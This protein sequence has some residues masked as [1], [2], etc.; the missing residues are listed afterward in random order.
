LLY[1]VAISRKLDDPLSA[2]VLSQSGAGK[3]G[4]T[5]VIEK[6]CPPE[7]IVLLTRLTPQSLYYVEPGFLDRKLVIVEE[8]Y[9]SIEADYSIRVLQSRKKLIAAAPVKDPATGNMRTK[10]FTVEA[11]AAFIEATTASSVNHEN[12]T[13]CF[14]LAMDETAEQT[15]RIH[16]RMS[17]RRTERGL[18][19]RAEAD[20]VSRRHWNAQRLL[21]PFPVV[22]PFADKLV[23]PSSWL[24]TRRDYA[25]F[26]NLIEVS[27]FLH[28]HQRERRGGAIVASTADYAVAYALAAE[29]LA[30][31]LSDLR[32]P[33]RDALERVRELSLKGGT[34][35]RREIREA[36]AMPDSTVRRWLSDL[37][38]LEYLTQV[39]AGAKGAGKTSRYR[40]VPLETQRAPLGL[41]SPE[42]LE[43]IATRQKPPNGSGDF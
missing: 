41:L 36:L 33:L 6:L 11:R 28:Q 12:A 14:E 22:I 20:E 24:R 27:A 15:R 7:D 43:E 31:T 17:L 18:K 26:L 32:K 42:A 8:R 35:S 38:E 40:L 10:V 19:Q 34:V 23:F 3:S 21:D 16:E 29:V 30:D 13:R 9:G 25:R 39:E 2:I 4:L 5:E 37:V 1:L